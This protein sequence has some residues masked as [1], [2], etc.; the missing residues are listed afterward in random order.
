VASATFI[1]G[2]TNQGSP[3]SARA[4]RVMVVDDSVVARRLISQIL[5]EDPEIEV[6]GTASSAELA[7]QKLPALQPDM[8]TLD[9]NMPGMSGLELL[10]ILRE[11]YPALKVMMVST[12]T[13]H[14]AAS[15]LDAL[16][17]GASDYVSKPSED[18]SL[19][20]SLAHMRDEILPKIKHLAGSRHRARS[21]ASPL[22]APNPVPAP[23]RQPALRP[24]ARLH[25]GHE[26]L[27]VGVSTGGPTAL[28]TFIA[29]F[30]LAFSLPIVIVQ[31]MPPVFTRLLA[32][33]LSAVTG[34][35]VV[36]ATSGMPLEPGKAIIAAGDHH[37]RVKRTAS[38]AHV[39]LD[40]GPQECS[41]R[42][43]VDV[44]FRSVGDAYGPAAI[45][46][47]LTG[48]GQDGLRGA[49]ELKRA[50]GYLIAQDEASSVVWGMPGAIANAGFADEVLDL[51][52]IANAILKKTGN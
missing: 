39:V 37:M 1:E 3:R 23:T 21:S 50:G 41:C 51:G 46:A 14:G 47:V 25:G 8:L 5:Q 9:I 48:M 12:L 31:H 43:S 42:P 7:L 35:R 40:Q 29:G 17:L 33:R 28:A 6:V 11:R 18:I 45:A 15:T 30:P 13:L 27:A 10:P 20:N 44:L 16:M 2:M 32:D 36:E 4:I 52:S 38:G 34:F 24:R 19:G 26:I 22:P 49:E